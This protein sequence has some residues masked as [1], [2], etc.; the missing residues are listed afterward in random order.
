MTNENRELLGLVDEEPVDK[1]SLTQINQQSI[2]GMNQSQKS[3]NKSIAIKGP[4]RI[5]NEALEI[6]NYQGVKVTDIN[7]RPINQS[8]A[9]LREAR[10]QS[11]MHSRPHLDSQSQA[12]GDAMSQ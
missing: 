5:I 4:P 11:S 1:D 12:M 7:V 9:K 8:I 2:L 6:D 10:E 3:P